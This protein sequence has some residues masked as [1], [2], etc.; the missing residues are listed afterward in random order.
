MENK[1]IEVK[2]SVEQNAKTVIA[3]LTF[4]NKSENSI[5]LNKQVSYYDGRVRNDYFEIKD[6]RGEC[7][8]YLGV[9]SNCTRMPDEYIQLGSG[10]TINSTIPLDE[11]YELKEGKKY[12]VQYCA[13][14]PSAKDEYWGLMEMESNKV[15]ISY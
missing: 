7:V 3:H 1:F 13:F 14:N 10:E 12:K 5:Y 15:V 11:F 4:R 2:L 6:S 9:M 8:D